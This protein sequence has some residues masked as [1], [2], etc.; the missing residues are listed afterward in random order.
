MVASEVPKAV[1]MLSTSPVARYVHWVIR[2][3]L[4]PVS[5]KV[6]K[7]SL[8]HHKISYSFE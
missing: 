4:L 6:A 3:P 7:R 1:V 2:E 8:K 5:V